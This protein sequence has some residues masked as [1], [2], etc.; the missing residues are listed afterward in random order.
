MKSL[1]QR[2]KLKQKLLIFILS[3]F[4]I[5]YGITLTYI[6][7]NL[8][9]NALN[10]SKEIVKSNLLQYR[11]LI[12]S[13][14]SRVRETASTLK[15]IFERYEKFD[16]E[17]R[18]TFYTDIL[19][20]WLEHNPNYL[21]TW[22]IWELRAFDPEYHLKNGR[23]R[24][25]IYRL[26]GQYKQSKEIV[27]RNNNNLTS[28]YYQTRE[29]NEE[30]IWNPYY[31]VVTPEL[32]GILMTSVAIPVQK[33]GAFI[34]LVGVDISL[35]SMSD[36]ISNLTPFQGSTSYLLSTNNSL[37]A[38]SD[39]TLV[40][41]HFREF[42]P[43]DTLRYYQG[44]DKTR[45][46][47]LDSFEYVHPE[48]GETH[49][50]MMTPVAIQG[51]QRLWT[52]GIEVPKKVV[53]K[54]ANE[55]FYESLLGGVV[56]LLLLYVL[57]YYMATKIV[58]PINKSAV[59]AHEIAEGKLSHQIQ[60]AQKDEVGQLAS[61]LNDMVTNLKRII[62]EIINCSEDINT[63][64]QQL[65]ESSRQ[66]STGAADQAAS[67]EEISS[68]MEEMVA[69]IQQNSENAKQTEGIAQRAASGM[70]Q[71]YESTQVTTQSMMEISEKI[72][73]IEE[74][75]RQTNILALNAAVE[76]ARAGEH[77]RG[78][79]VVAA[80]VKKL[81]ERSQKAAFDIIQLTNK[82]VE[83]ASQSGNQLSAIIPDI[84]KTSELV[85]EITAS[86][87]EQQSGAEQVNRAIQELNGVTQQNSESA[88]LF[89]SSA[90]DLTRLAKQLKQ[91]V[92]FFEQ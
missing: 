22:L 29:L 30:D 24:N 6:S 73:I 69:T 81:A 20:S 88:S 32:A 51:I 31:D 68:S 7:S 56:G 58:K 33:N 91:I 63:A 59:F 76:A 82:S 80:E 10:D 87:L 39:T 28:I 90:D 61:S 86:S 89:N 50:V 41:K 70:T 25:V 65:S 40:G 46:G 83:L 85:Q 79:S 36:I 9:K 37:V 60:I 78:F 18:D 84:Q 45:E 12:Q 55:I 66:L 75:A 92:S 15:D 64:S 19:Y 54:K 48:S 17:V 26:N 72:T 34:G 14:L 67:S 27:D 52:I 13:D 8:K 71:G 49:L 62:N 5:I 35:D 11:N 43:T 47:T 16:E 42:M 44:L 57:I 21:S 1:L 53:L 2:L 74:I 77:G 3:A 23:I 38:H 4:T